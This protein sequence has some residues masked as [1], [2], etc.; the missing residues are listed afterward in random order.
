M[1]GR[2]ISPYK[3]NTP[4]DISTQLYQVPTNHK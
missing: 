2:K 1:E 3:P 4:I